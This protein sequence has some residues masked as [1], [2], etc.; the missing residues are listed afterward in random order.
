MKEG[1]ASRA[2]VLRR[3]RV[4]TPWISLE[5]RHRTSEQAPHDDIT[6]KRK[7][8]RRRRKRYCMSKNEQTEEGKEIPTCS[9]A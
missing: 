5:H 1:S 4:A 6:T 9:H 7:R 3:A 2:P 8:M